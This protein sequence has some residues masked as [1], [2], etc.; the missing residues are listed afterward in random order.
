M[1]VST[2]SD[3]LQEG[4]ALHRHGA[5]AEAAARYTEVLRIEPGNADA[6]YYLGMMACQN[7]RFAEGAEYARQS[8][9]REPRHARAHVLLARALAAAGER[10]E[11]LTSFERA[12]ALA[13]DLAQAHGHRADVLGE[14]GRNEEAVE[15]YDRALVLAPDVVEDWF[16]RG[17]ALIALGRYEEAVAS[18]DRVL[19]LR[20]DF[21]QAHLLYAPRLLSKLRVCD[22]SDLHAETGRLLTAIREQR[23]VSVPFATLMVPAT[24]AEQLQCARRYVQDHPAFPPIWR[25]E[26]YSHDRIRVAYLSADFRDHACAYLT[27]GL[28]EQH[29][30][31]CFEITAISLGQND[32]SSMRQR[33]EAAFE[34]FIDVQG[35]S[36]Q[37]IADLIRRLEIDIVVDLMGFSKDNR[38]NVLARR[39]APIQ[40]NYLGYPG[41]LG[42]SYIDYIFADAT[43]VP[44]EQGMFYAEQVVRL[45]GTYLINDNKRYIAPSTPTRYECG[46]PGRAFVFCCFNNTQKLNP[47]MFDIWMRLLRAKEDGVLWLLEGSPAASGHLRA[48]AEQ[49]GV[50]PQRLIFAPKVN[51]ADHLARHRQADLFLD[52]LPCNAH[53]TASDALWVGLPVLT[54]LG[55]TF[56]GRVA[57]S[58]L[59]AMGLDEL[60]ASSLQE[61]EALA[62][63]LAQDQ[64][65][66]ATI[67]DKLARNRNTSILFDTKRAT[68]HFES[69]YLSM[70]DI[71]RRGESPR[72]FSVEP[73]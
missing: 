50:S 31:T 55:T 35:T 17:V 36:D 68:R 61:Y 49:R 64:A 71:L 58:L 42:A 23:A 4:L 16:S 9:A 47:E 63:K 28:F 60:V 72:S 6:H 14:L 29:D 69:A 38:L 30:R 51:V 15:S 59:R 24:A 39:P 53:T 13:P 12:I 44:E 43:V 67:K 10:D 41:T 1:I 33:M 73:A 26:I 46:L 54:C 40:L 62:L 21:P 65:Y 7:G 22:W 56:A 57:G 18:F 11:A 48:A 8:L 45:P 5:V 52:T 66:L 70:V 19:A 20:P 32:G 37:E 25:G 34:H 2:P 27:A 3:L